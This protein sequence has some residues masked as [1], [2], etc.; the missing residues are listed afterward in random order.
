VTSAGAIALR[1]LQ[2][3][4]AA[5]VRGRRPVLDRDLRRSAPSLRPA[6]LR[7]YATAYRLR[8]CE[9]LAADYPA[10]RELLGARAF[11][12]LAAAYVAA[13]PSRHP[14]LARFGA[15]FPQFLARRPLRQR[16]LVLGLARIEAAI[17]AAF[18]APEAAA[19]DATAAAAAAGERGR[20]RLVLHP[21]VQLL[22]CPAAAVDRFAAWRH[23]EVTPVRGGR[24][25]LCVLRSGEQVVRRELPAAA[26]ALL[27][28][29][30]R[31]ASL[32]S[33][34]AKL[35]AAAPVQQWFATWV[36]LGMFARR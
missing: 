8:L 29:L 1:T 27:R 4:F 12:R 18:D 14:D 13:R 33:A 28:R 25:E 17:T 6:R 35:P 32:A 3:R 31:G 10:T 11:D 9:V 7:I 20:L 21:S 19:L 2:R 23:G 16:H 5:V 22:R 36:G 26:A 30:Q 15:R 24:V 34:V